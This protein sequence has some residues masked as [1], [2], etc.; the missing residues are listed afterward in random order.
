LDSFKA[1]EKRLARAQR[2]LAR[3]VKFSANWH[4]QKARIAALHEHVTNARGDFLH[5]LSTDVCKNHA[6]ITSRIC[7]C[8]T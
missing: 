7:G 6:L 5:K 1:M 3:K 4:K 2:R 8:R